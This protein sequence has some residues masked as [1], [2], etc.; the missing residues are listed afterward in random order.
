M[1]T[2]P[3]FPYQ[4][5][6]DRAISGSFTTENTEDTET[7]RRWKEP[8]S[9]SGN[10]FPPASVASVVNLFRTSA[11]FRTPGS[12]EDQIA[13]CSRAPSPSRA[14]ERRATSCWRE[15][16][17]RWVRCAKHREGH[18]QFARRADVAKQ[19]IHQ[20]RAGLLPGEPG[21]EHGGY[22]VEPGHGHG[23]A[24]GGNAH[25]L[26]IGGGRRDTWS[27]F[28]LPGDASPSRKPAG[29]ASPPCGR[30]ARRRRR[31]RRDRCP[32]RRRGL[33][34]PSRASRGCG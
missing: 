26:G 12:Q 20:R 6:E 15:S 1:E 11:L 29:P 30:A 2:L 33:P 9:G 10:P 27:W 4:R 13:R 22:L 28:A 17:R 16:R 19:D 34:R 14:G 32:C 3:G 25:Y 5:F 18:W 21:V 23:R 8:G 24:G 7:D 31:R